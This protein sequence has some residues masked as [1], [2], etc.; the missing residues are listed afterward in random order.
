M[1]GVSSA[2]GK[3]GAGSGGGVP[4]PQLRS[5]QPTRA[6]GWLTDPIM[7]GAGLRGRLGIYSGRDGVLES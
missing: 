2:K 4:T 5:A 3:G 7:I 6:G 1:K